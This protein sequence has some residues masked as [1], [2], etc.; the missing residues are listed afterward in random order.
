[1]TVPV[2]P[3]AWIFHGEVVEA[4]VANRWLA[5][6]PMVRVQEWPG[7]GV[8]E[9]HGVTPELLDDDRIARALDAVAPYLDE[10]AAV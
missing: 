5:P 2:R 9:A 7:D 3:V 4:L 6:A 10:T 8:D 1:M